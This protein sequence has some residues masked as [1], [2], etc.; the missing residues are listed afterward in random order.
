MESLFDWLTT[1][2]LRVLIIVVVTG[3]ISRFSGIAVR[4]IIRR[5]MK[6]DNFSS[7][8]EEKLR[9]ETVS[10]LV[11]A[12]VKAMIWGLSF[13]I[14]LTE[15]NVNVA[16]LLA[17]GGLIGFAIGFGSQELV[18]DFIAGLFIVLE[19]QYRVGDVVQLNG[20]SG[21]VQTITLRATVIRDLDGNV[22]H[23][24][25]GS[26]E[27]A[28]NKTLEFARINMDIGISYSSDIDHVE[29]VINHVCDDL[30][31]DKDWGEYIIETPQFARVKSFADSSVIVKILG[32]VAPAKQWEVAG[33]MRRRLKKAFDKEGI[34]IP[35]PQV[36]VHTKK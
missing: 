24:P 19:N 29:K 14:I 18:K 12:V 36:D 31:K 30:A 34:E 15:L 11:V 21:T 6:P 25:N 16:P 9:E 7:K 17:G 3:S 26:I 27:L 20:V 32:K 13:L 22:H 28:T 33:E 2:G 35:F 8:R 5:A 10:K 4:R 1:T 23:F